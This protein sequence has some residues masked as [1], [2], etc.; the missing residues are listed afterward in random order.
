V[1]GDSPNQKCPC[2]S[3]KK[4][5]RCCRPYHGGDAAPTPEALMRSRYAAY[6]LGLADYVIDTTAAS[7][8][9]ARADRAVW[10]EE[11]LDFGRRTAFVG[12]VILGAGGEGDEGW[13]HFRAVLSEGGADV[14]FEERS[15]F[16]RTAGRW[17]YATGTREAV[18]PR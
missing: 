1:S 6:A 18:R 11:V 8:P 14:S 17:L 13:V 3:G 4:Y 5:K 7:G 10:T 16:V 9:R 12:L 15:G 2:H